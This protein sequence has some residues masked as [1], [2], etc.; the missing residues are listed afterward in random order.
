[1][2]QVVINM[3]RK[4]AALFMTFLLFPAALT[5][6]AEET[7]DW[8]KKI[9][10]KYGAYLPDTEPMTCG[11][12][13]LD[14]DSILLIKNH[15]KKV[16][17]W[18]NFRVKHAMGIWETN[19]K[20]CHVPLS[21]DKCT[22]LLKKAGVDFKEVTNAKGITHPVELVNEINGVKLDCEDPLIIDC[23]MALAIE[24]MT[25]ILSDMDVKAVGILSAHRPD[26]LYTFHALGLALDMN[27]F[28]SPRWNTGVWVQ[29]WFEK[30]TKHKTCKY[31]PLEERGRFL[32]DIA[33]AL[34]EEKLF[35]TILTPNYNP[36]HYNHF[37]VD[38]RPGD[39]RF[40]LN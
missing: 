1:M 8:I 12:G 5:V 38:L 30:R 20:K 16:A 6:E 3:R 10:E 24:K 26:S 27:W 23:D 34:W 19:I 32:M 15:F 37:H 18:P 14:D 33:C 21:K 36:G 35:N 28:K 31:K 9:I 22:G 29:S 25:R 4:S 13:D 7:S 11:S 39:N 2:I 17:K 40:Y